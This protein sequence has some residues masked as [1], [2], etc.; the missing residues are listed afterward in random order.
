MGKLGK[1]DFVGLLGEH[2]ALLSGHFRLSSGMHSSSYIQTALLLQY[3]HIS[4]KI[5]KAMA[6]KFPAEI[7]CVCSPAMGA[8]VIGQ[9]VARVK[10]CRA[11]FTERTGGSMS[12]RRD[13]HIERGEKILVVEDVLTTGRS[14]GEVVNLARQ[15]G[16]KV[17]G[18][19]AIVDRTVTTPSLDVP[20]RSL[21]SY[22]L[23]LYTP[24]NCQL[25]KNGVPLT[26]PGSRYLEPAG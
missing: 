4:N 15:Y 12:L 23:E 21:I 26:S 19:A 18:V 10:K 3:P 1:F 13:F 25:C 11:I 7:D 17:V 20:F 2:G 24:E 14:T 8:V 6:A 5:A 9:E 16:G 22:P